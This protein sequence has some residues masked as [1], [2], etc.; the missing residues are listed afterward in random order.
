[1]KKK[2]IL[3]IIGIILL[4]VAVGSIGFYSRI[5]HGLKIFYITISPPMTSCYDKSYTEIQIGKSNTTTIESGQKT[6]KCIGFEKE[7]TDVNFAGVYS[8]AIHKYCYGI[9]IASIGLCPFMPG[10]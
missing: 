6:G 4:L 9:T 7:I 8:D 2:V 5:D 3:L 10:G 1:M